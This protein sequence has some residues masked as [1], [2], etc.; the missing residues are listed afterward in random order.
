M[1]IVYVISIYR[2]MRYNV[3]ME[4]FVLFIFLMIF[5]VQYAFADFVPNYSTSIKYPGIG[6][7]RLSQKTTL[8]SEPSE[9]SHTVGI[10][11][12]EDE[13][14]SVR[15]VENTYRDNFVIFLPAQ[16]PPK[17][18]FKGQQEQNKSLDK[19]LVFS[20]VDEEGDNGWYKIYYSQTQGKTAWVKTNTDNFFVWKDF[21]NI[22]GVKNG[23]YLFKDYPEE[24]KR[25]YSSPDEQNAHSIDTI[26]NIAAPKYISMS[27]IRG[28]WMLVRVT[29]ISKYPKI[30]WMKWRD[31]TGKLLIFPTIKS[32]NE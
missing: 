10:L 1:E 32:K 6:L 2:L 22:F 27:I 14:K 12:W 21:Y 7:L 15:V 16:N 20:T 23:L 4:R 25:I 11:E 3:G 28:N 13:S 17:E 29:D 24:L 19:G 5:S 9:K 8:Y 31:E 26:D 18:L 30:G